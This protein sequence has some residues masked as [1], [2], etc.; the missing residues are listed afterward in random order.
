[1]DIQLLKERQAETREMIRQLG[2]VTNANQE[3]IRSWWM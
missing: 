1:V 3:M 2:E